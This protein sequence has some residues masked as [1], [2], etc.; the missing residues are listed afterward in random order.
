M[1]LRLRRNRRE[2]YE[3]LRARMIAETSAFLTELL[4]HPELAVRIPVIPAS[5]DRFPPSFAASFWQPVLL[6]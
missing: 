5:T 6:D 4:R 3:E 1:D 2:T